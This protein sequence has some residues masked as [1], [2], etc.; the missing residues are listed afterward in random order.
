LFLDPR[1]IAGAPANKQGRF[2]RNG[3]VRMSGQVSDQ[4]KEAL[5]WGSP[6]QSVYRTRDMAG[7][8]KRRVS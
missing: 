3:A 8:E 5:A 7:R 4:W 2:S 1:V 6:V